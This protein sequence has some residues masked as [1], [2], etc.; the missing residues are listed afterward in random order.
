MAEFFVAFPA[1]FGVSLRFQR[2]SVL[3]GVFWCLWVFFGVFRRFRLFQGQAK[4]SRLC[5][6]QLRCFG[7]RLFQ[8]G[9]AWRV[10]DC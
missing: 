7:R 9:S 4:S 3:L 1:F 6:E 5:G 2:F 8:T 10:R